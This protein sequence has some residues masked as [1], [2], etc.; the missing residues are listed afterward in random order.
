MNVIR[1]LSLASTT[2]AAAFAS[3]VLRRWTHRKPPHLLLW[4]I[5]LILYGTG[6]FAEFYSTI[7]WSPLLFRLW[8]LSGA[9][10]TAAYLGQGTV[11]L[12][13]RKRHVA[14][15]LMALLGLGSLVAVILVSR[16]PLDG[17]RFS[18]GLALSVQ[19]K[20]ILPNG[21]T[22][23]SMTPLFNIYGTIALVGGAIYSA[24]IFWRKRVLLHRALGNVFIAAGALSPALGGTFTRFGHPEY[25]SMALLV[26]VILMF[27]GFL[28]ATRQPAVTP[29]HKATTPAN[30]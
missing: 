27:V 17:S 18:P 22:I 15:G 28:F 19:Y 3:A 8:Y 20:E 4:G 5:G 1:L 16:V 7:G 2:L 24:W 26:G 6:T 14:N 12:L 30:M 21:A 29:R 13:V 11:Y 9:L 25:L 10:L 23:R